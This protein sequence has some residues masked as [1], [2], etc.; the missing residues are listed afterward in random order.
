[1]T[2]LPTFGTHE[3]EVA[4]LKIVFGEM[5]EGKAAAPF[6]LAHI[7]SAMSLGTQTNAP[8]AMREALIV[9]FEQAADILK[10]VG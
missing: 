6:I 4:R 7:E 5:A 1:M 8:R 2:R 9:A 10:S 3:Q